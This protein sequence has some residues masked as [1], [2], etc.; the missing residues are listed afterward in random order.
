MTQTPPQ[1]VRSNNGAMSR[2]PSP[3]AAIEIPEYWN[4]E[5]D[6][7]IT[8]RPRYGYGSPRHE[9]IAEILDRKRTD[10]RSTL[11]S[12]LDYQDRLCAI[13]VEDARPVEDFWWKSGWLGGLDI[14][15]LYGFVCQLRPAWYAEIGSGFS[16]KL[17]KRAIDECG[18]STRIA[19]ID[20]KPRH[21]IE[22]ICDVAIREPL[23]DADLS[24]FS[25]L[26]P[27]D[28]VFVDGSHRCLPNSDVTVVFLELLPMLPPDVYVG[29]HDIFLPYD[30]PP[31]WHD[32]FYSEQYVLAAQL[33]AEARFEIVLPCHYVAS[34]DD[35]SSILGPLWGDPRLHGVNRG[36]TS[37]WIRTL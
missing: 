30:Y 22:S 3:S 12:F 26:A 9:K 4:L 21:K 33:L 8:P 2:H 1:A 35:L 16:T 34:D 37:F 11:E 13:P 25:S 6:F 5:L 14:A 7:P 23:E 29:F 10:Y 18:A 19:S 20:P 24:L 28:I 15:P 36:G 17:V 27:G 32:R 31:E